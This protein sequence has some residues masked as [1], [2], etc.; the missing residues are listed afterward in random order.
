MLYGGRAFLFRHDGPNPKQNGR[1]QL[2]DRGPMFTPNPGFLAQARAFTHL[3]I[4]LQIVFRVVAVCVAGF[5][6]AYAPPDAHAQDEP[7]A[8]SAY[9]KFDDPGV[10]DWKAS[11]DK[12]RTL[13]GWRTYLKEAYESTQATTTDTLAPAPAAAS[14]DPSQSATPPASTHSHHHQHGGEK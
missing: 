12:V 10:S 6:F 3:Q 1:F 14:P 5:A 2:I 9:K 7:S 13:G 8:F 4:Q 11:N